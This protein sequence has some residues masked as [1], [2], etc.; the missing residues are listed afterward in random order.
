[1]PKV[2][3]SRD[4][5][6]DIPA[7]QVSLQPACVNIPNAQVLRELAERFQ[8]RLLAYR[9]SF[10]EVEFGE[11]EF[12]FLGNSVA[13]VANSLLFTVQGVKPLQAQLIELLQAEVQASA[14]ETL[15]TPE[16][17]VVE[18]VINA[19]HANKVQSLTCGDIAVRANVLAEARGETS[20]LTAKAV[21]SHLRFLSLPTRRIPGRGRGLLLDTKTRER[22]HES[23]Y[24][25]NLPAV[26]QP[27]EGCRNCQRKN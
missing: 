10:E 12:A 19:I 20:T 8:P 6:N 4:S 14:A 7:L 18:S 17:L 9:M 24:A 5:V 26:E 25:R 23:A 1:M 2:I 16:S 3:L 27:A 11:P 13:L 21:G 15:I 22:A